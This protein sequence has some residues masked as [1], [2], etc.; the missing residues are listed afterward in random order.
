MSEFRTHISEVF[1]LKKVISYK[2]HIPNTSPSPKESTVH[3][4][5]EEHITVKSLWNIAVF[6][7]FLYNN[8]SHCLSSAAVLECIS[9]LKFV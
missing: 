1:S 6:Q 9:S 5:L 2:Q 4:S 7:Y 8:Y 3:V